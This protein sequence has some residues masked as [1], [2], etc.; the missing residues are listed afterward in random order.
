MKI[1]T[2][3]CFFLLTS[4]AIGTSLSLLLFVNQCS[5]KDVQEKYTFFDDTEVAQYLYLNTKVI[6]K[7]S[8][9]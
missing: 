3:V 4:F 8:E 7:T 9:Y 1:K 6:N 2:K 5:D